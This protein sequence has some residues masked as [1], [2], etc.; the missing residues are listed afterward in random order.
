[1]PSQLHECLLLLFRNRPGLAAELLRESLRLELPAYTEARI[2]SAE[3]SQVQPAEYRADLVVLLDDKQHPVFGI[4]VE[5]QLAP[6][7]DKR[8]SWNRSWQCF[9]PWRTARTAL[10]R[11][12]PSRLRRWLP[13]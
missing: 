10:I 6:D 8:F 1:M 3:L 2:E 5:V 4:I 13:A 12:C 9:R 7:E 11:H